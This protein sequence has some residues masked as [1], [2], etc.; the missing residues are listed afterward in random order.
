MRLYPFLRS[1]KRTYQIIRKT[2]RLIPSPNINNRQRHLPA[3][4]FWLIIPSPATP[5][6]DEWMDTNI[7]KLKIDTCRL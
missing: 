1:L 7:Y 5:P 2:L 4:P 6:N 3:L